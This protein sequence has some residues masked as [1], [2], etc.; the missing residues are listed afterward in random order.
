M[1][2][3]RDGLSTYIYP[4]SREICLEMQKN[5]SF[6]FFGKIIDHLILNGSTSASVIMAGNIESDHTCHGGY[7]EDHKGSWSNVLVQATVQIVLQ[8]A[9]APAKTDQNQII[10]PNGVVCPYKENIWILFLGPRKQRSLF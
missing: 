9:Y 6:K 4:V 5:K 7:Y 3:V 10:L 1:S 8:D 2:A